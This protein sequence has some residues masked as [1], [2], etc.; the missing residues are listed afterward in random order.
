MTASPTILKITGMLAFGMYAEPDRY[1]NLNE[2]LQF[3][4]D[5]ARDRWVPYEAR[6][7]LRKWI[8]DANSLLRILEA[9]MYCTTSEKAKP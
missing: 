3:C 2:G 5:V 6:V 7:L 9:E 1:D 8:E 4:V